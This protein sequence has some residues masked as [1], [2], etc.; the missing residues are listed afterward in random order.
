IPFILIF[1][2]D[3]RPEYYG[4]FPDGENNIP[5]SQIGS[6]P[7][8]DRALSHEPSPRNN[9]FALSQAIRTKA[10]WILTVS[11]AVQAYFVVGFNTHCIPF[12]TEIG[13]DPIA[14]GG[15]MGF[16]IVF[17]IPSRFIGGLFA[18]RVSKDRLNLLLP[19]PFIFLMIGVGAYLIHQSTFT[20]YLLLILY[21]IGH[22]LPAPLLVVIISRYFG[23]KAF[24][25]ILGTLFMFASPAALSAPVLTGWLFD[26]TG[27]YMMA[28]DIFVLLS[29]ITIFLLGFLKA[30]KPFLK[31]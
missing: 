18:D 7:L 9:E 23:R 3:K 28:F 16:M 10:Y 15:M 30:P 5:R 8:F 4:L 24:G 14:A 12:L 25:S 2:R 27:D 29:L 26:L 17:T 22:G 1:V 31:T 21:G 13:I 19:L 6:E 11:F 20:V